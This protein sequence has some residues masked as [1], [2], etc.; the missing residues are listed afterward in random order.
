[1]ANIAD[2]GAGRDAVAAL[3]IRM[4]AMFVQPGARCEE[5]RSH[6]KRLLAGLIDEMMP[7]QAELDTHQVLN[8]LADDL[9]VRGL[10]KLAADD[11]E[12]AQLRTRL[13]MGGVL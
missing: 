13:V 7:S 6:A 3:A 10:A 1:M 5:V 11:C 8:A 12:K 4:A 2:T 9:V